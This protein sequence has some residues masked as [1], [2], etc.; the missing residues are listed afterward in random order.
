MDDNV[1]VQLFSGEDPSPFTKIKDAVYRGAEQYAYPDEN[2]V[3]FARDVG[4][5]Y[6]TP[7]EP[8][9]QPGMASG[10]RINDIYEGQAYVQRA[11]D[12]GESQP[13]DPMI[14]DE[15]L[16][17]MFAQA[18]LAAKR[19]PLM[20]LGFD[21]RKT[22]AG[23]YEN[24]RRLSNGGI[25]NPLTDEMYAAQYSPPAIA[26]ESMH[27]GLEMLERANPN[28]LAENKIGPYTEELLVRRMMDT[29]WPDEEMRNNGHVG[30]IEAS[31]NNSYKLDP[32]IE[33]VEALAAEEIK[34][35][36]PGGPR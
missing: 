22:V 32:I 26:H 2:D 33:I 21:P 23:M 34:N 16:A 27:R 35:R 25:Y 11:F 24:G 10:R 19:S 30:Q 17:Q 29:Y 8:F 14:V 4:F 36:T 18:A 1:L 28:F 6:G 7:L 5:G 20:S 31:R 15:P 3:Q 13:V 12:T 9:L